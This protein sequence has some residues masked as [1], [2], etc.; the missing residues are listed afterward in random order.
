MHS[1]NNDSSF[2]KKFSEFSIKSNQLAFCI[3]YK[4]ETYLWTGI[5]PLPYSLNQNILHSL[6]AERMNGAR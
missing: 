6:K 4:S 2:K 1:F 5:Q 3:L